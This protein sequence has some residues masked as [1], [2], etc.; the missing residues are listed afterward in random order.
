MRTIQRLELFAGLATLITG[1]LSCYFI[2]LP[3]AKG[4]E[5][6]GY[7]YQETFLR[8]FFA[9]ILPGFLTLVGAYFHTAR[10]SIVGLILI[11]VFA[12]IIAFLH[13]VGVII[14]RV[15]DRYV[16]LGVLPGL[17]AAATICFALY[18]QFLAPN[19]TANIKL[20]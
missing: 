11:F 3:G 8:A 19:H 13:A 9:L 4:M 18:S 1:L 2:D 16:L 7:S 17:F 5:E 12:G 6:L 15:P 10:Q 20:R 14:G